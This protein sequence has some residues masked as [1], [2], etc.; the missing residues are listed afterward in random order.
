[1]D[2]GR[3]VADEAVEN[4]GATGVV[5]MRVHDAG[6]VRRGKRIRPRW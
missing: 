2:A 4:G 6:G 1:V 5:S 3:G